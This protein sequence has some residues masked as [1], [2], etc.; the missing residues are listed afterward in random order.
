MPGLWIDRNWERVP[1]AE[2]PEAQFHYA[3]LRAPLEQREA[4]WLAVSGHWPTSREWAARSY[5]QLARHLLTR[6]DADRLH[7]LAGEIESWKGAQTREKELAEVIRA[8]VHALKDDLEGVIEAF[9][10]KAN[11]QNLSDPALLELGLEVIDEAEEVANR[12]NVEAKSKLARD[13]LQK[14]RQSLLFKLMQS[15][16]I[17]GAIRRNPQQNNG[18]T[19]KRV[20]P[21]ADNASAT[22]IS[23]DP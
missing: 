9:N 11:P 8:G 21:K 20:L 2:T 6:N 18:A 7:V 17:G 10:S 13:S 3:Q 23:P 1:R 14:I 15:E 4:A 12:P 5:T 19:T 22:S 16:R